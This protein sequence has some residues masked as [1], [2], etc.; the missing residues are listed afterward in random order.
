MVVDLHTHYPMHVGPP[1]PRRVALQVWSQRGRASAIDRFDATV[2][3]SASRLW[4]WESATAGPRVTID[5]LRAGGVGVA[6]SVL[7]SPLLEMGERLTRWYSRKPPYGAPPEDHYTA[8]LMRQMTAVERRVARWHPDTVAIARS[9]AELDAIHA[10]GK[11]ALVHC[12]EGGFSLGANAESIQR[13]VRMLAARGVAYV[14]LAH[15]AWRHVATNVPCVPFASD[16]LY[17][18]IFPQPSVGLS[19]LGRAAVR[20]MVAAGVLIDITHMSQAALEDTFA[21]LDELDPEGTVPVMASHC[22][23]RFGGQA[24]NLD[25]TTIRRVAERDG[26]VGLMLSTYFMADGLD[27]EPASF[28]ESF[29]LLCR[30][31]DAIHGV[32]GSYANLAV[33]TDLDGFVKPTLPGLVNSAQ[34]RGLGPALEARYG[35]AAAEAIQSGN[36]MRVL[37]AGWCATRGPGPTAAAI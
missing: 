36:A 9:P 6:L 11:L 28:D 15:L 25:D 7:C 19:E 16:E 17:N 35:R 20:A 18:K 4:N 1:D 3:R 2:L 24:Y 12:V 23:Y 21:L 27:A 5:S 26:V 22:G 30:H 32:T 14:T 10:A 13:T 37:R 33:G 29:D 34:L 31:V 8:V